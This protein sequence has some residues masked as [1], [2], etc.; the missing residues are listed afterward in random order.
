MREQTK[1]VEIPLTEGITTYGT[2]YEIGP[3]PRRL[4]N[5][6]RSGSTSQG[7]TIARGPQPL[8]T[9]TA[10]MAAADAGHTNQY[11]LGMGLFGAT[12]VVPGVFTVSGN[13]QLGLWNAL[14]GGALHTVS[15]GSF[16]AITNAGAT[17]RFPAAVA[18]WRAQD[19]VYYSHI[20]A[21][22]GTTGIMQYNGSVCVAYST[23]NTSFTGRASALAIHLE[24]LFAA[25]PGGTSANGFGA[26]TTLVQMSDTNDPATMRAS[27]SFVVDDEVRGLLRLGAGDLDA[28]GQAHLLIG[29]PNLV[30]S[31]DGDP[32]A[33]NAS[34]RVLNDAVGPEAPTLWT[35]TPY[36]VFLLASDGQLYRIAQG[37]TSLEP[38]GSRIRDRFAGFTR[39][40]LSN[41]PATLLW[42]PPYL[43][44]LPPTLTTSFSSAAGMLL[45]DLSNPGAPE[46]T[47]P[48]T[49]TAATPIMG[50]VRTPGTASA[51]SAV[52]FAERSTS[53]LRSYLLADG[54]TVDGLTQLLR[55]GYL[56]EPDHDVILQRVIA[57]VL[58]A[59]TDT[60]FTCRMYSDA[61][62][63]GV[64]TVT[65]TVPGNAAAQVDTRAKLVFASPAPV[66]GDAVWFEL[67]SPANKL[68][69]LRRVLAE[70]RV[71][72]RQD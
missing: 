51:A 33:G 17:E 39:I 46:W 62:P 47:G 44:L 61:M 50:A 70:I 7:R 69:S 8:A 71:V 54:T 63:S 9:A 3:R 48:H 19:V 41:A 20:Q 23:V 49:S 55:T 53:G 29:G 56:S 68:L 42:E 5:I 38:V 27:R 16:T 1:L 66:R 40:P 37:A 65:A 28:G 32:D 22:A 2:G 72:P 12:P 64:R 13:A 11:L 6:V 15:G 43:V 60:T 45:M 52:Y 67:E 57:V 26:R 14:T 35:N 24:R 10:T 36:G 25:L 4:G 21:T 30:A 31:F 58:P 59:I 18:Y 34:Y